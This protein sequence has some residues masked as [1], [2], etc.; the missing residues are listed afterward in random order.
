[1][2]HRFNPDGGH[3]DDGMARRAELTLELRD[4]NA[5]GANQRLA[6]PVLSPCFTGDSRMLPSQ[7]ACAAGGGSGR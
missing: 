5:F 7:P 2:K 3:D 4:P 1:M 6:P